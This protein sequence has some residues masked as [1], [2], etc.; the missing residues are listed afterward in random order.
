MVGGY[1][2]D[3]PNVLTADMA[4]HLTGLVRDPGGRT[5]LTHDCRAVRGVSG[6][7]LLVRRGSKWV[8]AGINVAQSRTGTQGFAVPVDAFAKER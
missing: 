1:G 3:N 4:C 2:Q 5:L 8:I 6:A 7:P